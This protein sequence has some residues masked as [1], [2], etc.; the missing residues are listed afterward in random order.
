MDLTEK[1]HEAL[2]A[3]ATIWQIRGYSPSLGEIAAAIAVS[4]SAAS[5]LV[6]AVEKRGYISR[7]ANKSR[8][9]RILKYP[10]PEGG[11]ADRPPQPGIYTTTH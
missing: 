3:I 5:V 8:T 10:T 11:P 4:R 2:R 7:E 1:Q 9:I 6:E